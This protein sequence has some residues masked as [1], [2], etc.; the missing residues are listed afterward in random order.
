M[1]G[2]VPRDVVMQQ[3]NVKYPA[4]AGYPLAKQGGGIANSSAAYARREQ[5]DILKRTELHVK[6]M[7]LVRSQLLGKFLV[8]QLGEA[9]VQQYRDVQAV[10]PFLPQSQ[11]LEEEERQKKQKMLERSQHLQVITVQTWG[12]GELTNCMGMEV[13]HIEPWKRVLPH[14]SGKNRVTRRR[15][16]EAI[17]ELEETEEESPPSSPNYTGNEDWFY[18]KPYQVVT[19][20]VFQ[21]CNFLKPPYELHFFAVVQVPDAPAIGNAFT[22]GDVFTAPVWP[23]LDKENPLRSECFET[24]SLWRWMQKTEWD[25]SKFNALPLAW[26]VSLSSAL[27]QAAYQQFPVDYID[28]T[29]QRLHE[30]EVHLTETRGRPTCSQQPSRRQTQSMHHE[31]WSKASQEVDTQLRAFSSV[32]KLTHPEPWQL[33]QIL[34]GVE[35]PQ[36]DRRSEYLLSEHAIIDRRTRAET[37]NEKHQQ[38]HNR[39]QEALREAEFHREDRAFEEFFD[40]AYAQAVA[41]MRDP[42]ARRASVPVSRFHRRLK[43]PFQRKQAINELL[44]DLLLWHRIEGF[45]Y[46]CTE[47]EEDCPEGIGWTPKLKFLAGGYRIFHQSRMDSEGN[48]PDRAQQASRFI[49]T[50]VCLVEDLQAKPCNEHVCESCGDRPMWAHH[51]TRARG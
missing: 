27:P 26:I 30:V 14:I 16:R 31:S 29:L 46:G 51:R 17:P 3:I 15:V 21:N 5:H 23:K 48:Q 18:Y 12:P 22:F 38:Q 1:S 45:L 25:P 32:Q 6:M 24:G 34:A 39:T 33:A 8:E 47:L 43:F 36:R 19:S 4:F 10:F 41:D 40:R 20:V 28:T 49:A 44:E 11:E 7:P 35:K 9:F 2:E 42:I 50:D 13:V 37:Y